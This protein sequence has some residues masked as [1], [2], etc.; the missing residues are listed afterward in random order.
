MRKPIVMLSNTSQYWEIVGKKVRADSYFGSTDGIHTVSIAISEFVGGVKIQGTLELDPTED[1]W[2]DITL[3][4]TC[5]NTALPEVRYPKDPSAPTGTNG[6]DSGVDAFTF[7]GNFTY[8]RA[9]VT[10]AHM[11]QTP[12]NNLDIV[13]LG[14]GSVKKVLLSL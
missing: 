5:D 11:G 8:L 14:V 10:R 2:F 3:S 6:G 4:S 9:A 13:D 12:D 1:D 7:V